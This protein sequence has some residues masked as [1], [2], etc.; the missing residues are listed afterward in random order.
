[1]AVAGKPSPITPAVLRW[2]LEQDARPPEAVA[3]LVGVPAGDLREWV[4][5]EEQP[6]VGQVSKLAE[7]L[8]RPRVFFFLPAP[9]PNAALADGFRHPPGAESHDVSNKV[10]LEVRRCKRLQQAVASTRPDD[11]RV[12]VPRARLSDDPVRKAAEVRAWLGIDNGERWGDE[13]AAQRRWREALDEVGVLVFL[14]QLGKDEVRGFASW[15][16]RAPMIVA[17]TSSV[18]V[19]ARIFTFGHELAH[20]VLR[21][22]TACLEPRGRRLVID[23]TT[24]RWCERFAAA[25][26]MPRDEVRALMVERGVGN[27]QAGLDEVSL[28]MR[29]FRVSARAAAVR[30]EDLNYAEPDL[31]DHVLAVFKTKPRADSSTVKS[32][33][34]HVAR[35]RQYGEHT[36]EAI[37]TSM[38]P[39][40]ALSVLRIDVE[41]ARKLADEVPGVV[42]I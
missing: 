20:L 28:T 23:S 22:A 8:Q 27:G 19:P 12:Q 21:E 30:L 35:V 42:A 25:L 31:Y 16:E 26:L 11:F 10:V 33:P 3:E 5:G 29:R 34:R 4:E 14:L 9:P 1:M 18:N 36:I 17:N 2:A 13:Y 15:D 39:R 41:D 32:A 40:D 37:M 38:P 24:E 7:V 6:T